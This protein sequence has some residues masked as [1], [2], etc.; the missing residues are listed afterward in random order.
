[1][2][3]A[4]AKLFGARDIARAREIEFV[5]LFYWYKRKFQC[6]EERRD[7]Y[8]DC[9]Q[10]RNWSQSVFQAGS[11]LHVSQGFSGGIR[12]SFGVFFPLARIAMFNMPVSIRFRNEA[13]NET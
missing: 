12:P 7:E 13:R 3:F 9:L 8:E 1:M 5:T 11:H 6:M 2:K 10:Y 4:R